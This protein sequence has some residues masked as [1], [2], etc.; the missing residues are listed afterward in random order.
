MLNL[1]HQEKFET[2]HKRPAEC[3]QFLQKWRPKKKDRKILVWKKF[4]NYV[5]LKKKKKIYIYIY[6]FF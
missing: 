4:S 6:D 3:E 2:R 1:I 5:K